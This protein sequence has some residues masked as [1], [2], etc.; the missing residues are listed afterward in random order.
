MIDGD[1]TIIDYGCG[2]GLS[3]LNL[4]CRWS[5]DDDRTWQDYLKSVILIEPSK[6]ALNRAEAIAKLKFPDATIRT[7]NKKLET[8]DSED[9]LFDTNK[10]TIHIFSQVLDITLA[11]EFNLLEFFETITSTIGMHYIHVVSHEVDGM[12]NQRNILKLYRYIASTYVGANTIRPVFRTPPKES[13]KVRKT[14]TNMALNT[15]NIP[16][17]N[18][19]YTAMFACI[20]TV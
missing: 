14:A 6:I 11:D 12:N 4:V 10:V 2:Q 1:T 20:K 16:R 15:F 9:L 8:L 19:N 18:K 5:H 3:F 7:V 17:N 13:R